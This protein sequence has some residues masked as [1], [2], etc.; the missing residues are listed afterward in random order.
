MAEFDDLQRDLRGAREAAETADA[1]LRAAA[2]RLKRL[3]GRAA[4]LDRVSNSDNEEHIAAR[5]RL[6]RE[7]AAE[8]AQA[9][10]LQR[11]RAE[12]L[13]GEAAVLEGFVRFTDPREAIS[14]LRDDTPI[15]LLPV[16]L[17]T[18]FKDVTAPGSPA[19]VHELWVRIYP[20][21]CWI[22][23]FDPVLTE[24]EVADARSY[25][26]AIWGA[27]GVET[28]ERGAWRVLAAAHGSGR[29]SW[30]VQAYQ[31]VNLAQKPSKP[32]PEDVVLTIPV[33]AAL[34]SGEAAAA[35]AFWRDA[36]LAD[37]DAGRIRLARQALANTVG[38]ERADEIVAGNEPANFSAPLP[39]GVTKPQLN[40]SVAFVVFPEAETKQ[41]AWSRAPRMTILPDRFVFI[42]YHAGGDPVVA[43]GRPVP[44]AL[45]AGPDP[46]LPRDQQIQH[47]AQGNLVLPDGMKWMVD[48]DR[49]VDAGM[50]LRIRLTPEQAATGFRRVLVL[51]LRVNADAKAAA[52]ELETLLRHHAWSRTGLEVLPQG[53]PTNNTEAV[54]A[55]HGHGDD[56]DQSFDDLKGPLFTPD[57]NWLDKKDGQWVAEYLG[58]D[59]AVF[60][61][62]HGAD[63]SDQLAG[64]AM[65]VALWPAILGYWMETMMAPV[66]PRDAIERTRDFFNGYVLGAGAVPAI[67]IGAQPYGIL[68]A[69][70]LSRMRWLDQPDRAG[71][72]PYLRRLYQ[73]L[74]AM[75][76]DWRVQASSVA[77]AAKAGD[78][79]QI[80]LDILGLH[81]G[82]VEWTQ[83]YA[84]SLKT[85]YNRLRLQR[86]DRSSEAIERAVERAAS[87]ALLTRLGYGGDRLPAILDQI[88]SGR[89]QLLKG[90]VVD[91]RPLSETDRIRAWATGD[92]NYVRWLI[93]AA[94]TSLDALYKQEGFENDTPPGVL[95]Y[96]L[97][98][99][100]LQLGY[101]D[102][103]IRLHEAAG[104]YTADRAA[105]ARADDPFLHI[106]ASAQVSES[107][108][109][110]LYAAGPAITGGAFET[111]GHFI[112]ARLTSLNLAFYLRDQ[113]AA[114]ERLAAQPTARLERA[115]ADHM[116]CCAY[117]LDAWL[118][119]LVHYQLAQMRGLRDRQDAAPRQGLYLGAYACLEPLQPEHKVLM[120]VPLRDP[121]LVADFEAAGEPPLMRDSTNQGYV[122][123]PSLNHAVA[124]AVLR[125]G[126]ISNASERNRRTLAVN[127][128]SE[129]VR[130]ALAMLEGIRGG[131]G[132]ADLL[133]Y[134][135]ERGLHD[136]HAMAEV[137]K[138]IYKL[139]KVFPLRADRMASTRTEEGVPI[140]VIEARNVVDGLTL[141]QHINA[142]GHARYPFGKTTLPAATAAEAA[143]IDA[144]AERLVETH[145]AVAD[146]ALSEGVYQAVLGNYDR[147]AST[148]DA[149]ARGNFP[150][151]P[152]IVRTPF[153][154]IG[155]THRVGVHLASGASPA[156]SP[157]PGVAMTPRAQAEPAL[158]RWLA[159]I[160]PVPQQVGCVV[161]F[162][163]APAG[164]MVERE[165]TLRDLELQPL[166]LVAVFP[167]DSAQAMSELD[168]RVLRFSMSAF[169]V[170][171]DVPVTIQYMETRAA[172][173]SVFQAMPLVRAVRQVTT[174]S[175]PLKAT[176]LTLSNE[177]E[178]RQDTDVFVDKARLDAVRATMETLRGQ[179][180]VFKAD[181]EGP[182]SD[183]EN[184]RGE[185]L[186][187]VD[188]YVERAATLL[189]RASLYVVPQAGW[190]FAY[191]F[192]RGSYAAILSQAAGLVTRWN[193]RLAEFV[194]LTAEELALPPTATD[195]E[196]FALLT[197][198]EPIVSS[199]ATTP[200]PPTPAAFRAV[201]A[202]K[203]AAFE[204]KRDDFDQLKNATLT[205]VSALHAAVAALLPIA[206]FDFVD[207]P[208]TPHEDAMVRF[209]E[210]VVSV[211]AAVI[212][213][214]DRRLAASLALFTEHDEAAG[215]PARVS[216]LEK[217]A[218]ALLG[219]DFRIFPEFAL[220]PAQGAELE[221]ALATSRSGDLFLH[222]TAPPDPATPPLDFVADTWLHG[223]ARVRDKMR[224]WEQIV[225]M[226]GS[227]ERPEPGLDPMQFPFAPGDRWL[228]LEFPADQ[229]LDVD[230]LLYTAHFAA[231]FDKTVRQA[232]LLVDEWTETIPGTE[233]D[234]GITFH[235]DRPDCEAPQT[236]LLVTPS[237]FR[238]AWQWND[239]VDAL[240][241][242]LDLAPLRA[243][244]PK[245]VDALP[246]AP[247]LPATV[248]ATQAWQLTI[249]ANLALNN[250]A[251]LAAQKR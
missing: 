84:E 95:L 71:T 93:D 206:D 192:K 196:R 182:L 157:L 37:G 103:S 169:A 105:I 35:A 7:T 224:A 76:D 202:A 107:R 214:L 188:V 132:L 117:R 55:G 218:R 61:H 141:V 251:V 234:T 125:N 217:A 50:G 48:F 26:V 161:S 177:A 77:F 145:D 31:P 249:A 136:R 121:D 207:F 86:F 244:E 142:T 15:L 232:G 181:V 138:F 226:A 193:A 150:P 211:L 148:Y 69:T 200:L 115:F 56:P 212:A 42:G 184:R 209:A 208:L 152:D 171:P 113:V 137:D 45:A 151:E 18:R 91:D 205:S 163:D 6:R 88:F 216:A 179:L 24:A 8:E 128:T 134:Q 17:E 67:R 82:S 129:R 164:A 203:Q 2:E 85:V 13:R 239:L 160:L 210:D 173:F 83:R 29:A 156:V 191:D 223:L 219:D 57:A 140:E 109:Q 63:G 127:L 4:Q 146:L 1:G 102:V 10:R 131:Q 123:A 32:R 104:L 99:H 199:A 78:P 236:M 106:R 122:H 172:T 222:L 225:I 62:V 246:Y 110:P 183:L 248:M 89:H 38:A 153:Q 114:L 147:V 74:L 166:D 40:V 20:D 64:R 238:G 237:E 59:P 175:R 96:L 108:Y 16:R 245:H 5:E 143:A 185:I 186:A 72:R 100:A 215:A 116:D 79:H 201:L 112:G 250:A 221:N 22:D 3:A 75:R 187:D 126:F 97:L 240:N 12:A 198:A 98:R 230:R 204:G 36:W 233:A 25:W 70:A 34:P 41:S 101:H 111:V 243:L 52:T 87:R 174:R 189:S 247:F 51:G 194:A 170:R 44:A 190:G 43:V 139:R 81:P 149:Y 155:L 176:D 167:D 94:N 168:D 23:G 213:E 39:A 118:L 178:S 231:V 195:D 11:A 47:D 19:P 227:L 135:F 241:E 133:G 54:H 158:N 49:A 197:R 21:D 154:G 65:N 66:F 229:A 73:L 68:P 130:T 165:V 242:T 90:G 220:S 9:A 124:A 33:D 162:R 235:H 14:R 80:L 159:E 144:E 46:S 180:A 58:I 30:I 28:Q 92:R 228:G 119:G 120:P 27:G 53:T 60:A